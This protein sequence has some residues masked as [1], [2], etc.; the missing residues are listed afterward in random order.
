M[1][2]TIVT[3]LSSLITS[4]PMGQHSYTFVR[5]QIRIFGHFGRKKNFYIFAFLHYFQNKIL[6]LSI[7]QFRLKIMSIF[8][9]NIHPCPPSQSP[10]NN[11]G[12]V[13]ALGGDPMEAAAADTALTLNITEFRRKFAP[14][15]DG[16]LLLLCNVSI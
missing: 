5:E 7:G 10:Q 4:L 15:G 11:A 16:E 8:V 3:Y 12:N 13:P 9:R 14:Q 1:L 2:G 6:T